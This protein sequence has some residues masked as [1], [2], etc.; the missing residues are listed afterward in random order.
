MTTIRA[1]YNFVPLNEIIYFPQ[2]ADE[3]SH[4]IPFSDG[5]SGIIDITIKAET[6]IF[7][8]NG[9]ISQNEESFSYFTLPDGNK[10]FFIPGTSVKGMI[11]NVME[12][13]SFGKMQFVDNRRYTWRDLI[14][15]YTRKFVSGFETEPLVKAGFIKEIDGEWRLFPCK[16]ARIEQ[17]DLHQDI[18]TKYIKAKEK[19]DFWEK[20][21]KKSLINQF[22]ISCPHTK[23][24]LKQCGKFR[25]AFVDIQKIEH[26][27][28]DQIEKNIGDTIKSQIQGKYEGHIVFTGQIKKRLRGK[29]GQHGDYNKHLEFVFFDESSDSFTIN[30]QMRRDFELNHSDERNKEKHKTALSPNE[31]WGF[32]K[33][34]LQ[35]GHKMPVF[36]LGSSEV[37]SFGMAMLFRLPLNNSVY[38]LIKNSN[39]NHIKH[40]VADKDKADKDIEEIFAP[41]LT[42]CILGY[43]IG[44][45]SLK[46][47]VQFSH[48]MCKSS[49]P[50]SIECKHEILSSP[51]PTF[52]P[53]YLK[54]GN[55]NDK[56]SKLSGRKRYPVHDKIMT[57]DYSDDQIL[58]NVGTRFKPLNQGTEFNC[59][60]RFHNLRTFEIGALLT[61]ITFYN[62][63]EKFYHSLGM[64]KP[65]GYGKVKISVNN[66]ISTKNSDENII[67][68]LSIDTMKDYMDS[69]I[70]EIQKETG[71]VWRKEKSIIELLTMASDQKNKEH[72]ESWLKY[73]EMDMKN[74]I[75]EFKDVKF[76]N[77]KLKYYSD[78]GYG[79]TKKEILLKEDL[80]DM[81]KNIDKPQDIY[82]IKK[83][84]PE[85]EQDIVTI[86]ENDDNMPSYLYEPFLKSPKILI[87]CL[88]ALDDKSQK[89]G[90]FKKQLKKL[91]D[92]TKDFQYT[93]EDINTQKVFDFIIE[94]KY[95]NI[96]PDDFDKLDNNFKYSWFDI[97]P[98]L[99]RIDAMLTDKNNIPIWPPINELLKYIKDGGLNDEEKELIL[100]LYED[101]LSDI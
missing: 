88:K 6:P 40:L 43:S 99:N 51:K 80:A 53:T 35:N 86:L 34:R 37:K 42:D 62:N 65:L 54:N 64:A 44:Q 17:C 95:K 46:G 96:I 89:K 75:N 48:A 85:L 41:D 47:R 27:I 72:T 91:L 45:K 82:Q 76:E 60:V 55:Y 93:K 32:W 20:D 2:W 84:Y 8:R 58:N 67:K 98:D 36:W 15:N 38:D 73:L 28:K 87:K 66:I 29:E 13:I 39:E 11:R 78:I 57:Y 23:I 24:F 101:K 97:K 69:F 74:K 3:I 52:Y 22:S 12:I 16:F 14:D 56:T 77:K 79:I 59:K 33:K 19:Y 50:E 83:N 94:K 61:S 30:K 25:R 7:I 63:Q 31:E 5:Q 9:S 10:Q 1:P 18:G 68:N 26:S 92:K 81:L 21:K 49:E 71:I 100:E 70:S 4:D 90:D